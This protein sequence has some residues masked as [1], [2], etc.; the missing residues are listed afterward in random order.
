MIIANP[1]L[2]PAPRNV[3][4]LTSHIDILPTLLG[5]A[6]LDAEALRRQIEANYTDAAPLVGRDLSQLVLGRIDPER[7][8]EPLYYMTDDDPSRGLDQVNFLGIGYQSVWQPNHVEAVIAR[9]EEGHIWKLARYFD[10]PRFWSTPP[11]PGTQPQDVVQSPPPLMPRTQEDG[12][13]TVP[14]HVTVKSTPVSDE[15][16]MYD[17]SE[18]PM[19]LSN[20][21]NDS[22]FDAQRI[23]LLRLLEEQRREKR[24]VPSGP[25]QEGL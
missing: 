9:M 1:R 18:D 20:L 12:F 15:F 25:L 24:L 16:E 10:N 19:E 21:A 14:Y 4:S 8:A 2:F 13:Y 6:G 11:G 23:R 3:S 5:L 22:A 7:V 17:V